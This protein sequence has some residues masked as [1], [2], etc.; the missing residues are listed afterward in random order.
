MKTTAFRVLMISQMAFPLLLTSTLIPSSPAWAGSPHYGYGFTPEQAMLA[1]TQAARRESSARCLGKD[2]QADIN[3]DC[4]H[5]GNGRS[6][7]DEKGNEL[8]P[9]KCVAEGS[10]HKGSC[11]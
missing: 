5:A 3:R 10:N 7:F 1:A 2:W 4:Q 11:R 9:Y 6:F 8:G